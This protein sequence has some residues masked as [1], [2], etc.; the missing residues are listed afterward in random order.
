MPYTGISR[1]LALLTPLEERNE[2]FEALRLERSCSRNVSC[3]LGEVRCRPSASNHHRKIHLGDDVG[4]NPFDDYGISND[5]F[6]RFST[7]LIKKSNSSPLPLIDLR[8]Y[9]NSLLK[10]LH[11]IV[12]DD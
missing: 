5:R 12:V 9:A 3:A 11:N 7:R 2:Q 10:Q 4:Q 1:A 8:H 6:D